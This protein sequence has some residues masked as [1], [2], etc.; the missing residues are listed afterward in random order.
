[1]K[2][3]Q[4]HAVPHLLTQSLLLLSLSL[5]FFFCSLSCC[6]PCR[7]VIWQMLKTQVPNF[8]CFFPSSTC[9]CFGQ[10]AMCDHA[11]TWCIY[12]LFV[13]L[14]RQYAAEVK[15]GCDDPAMVVQLA[16]A[17]LLVW[18]GNTLT[19]GEQHR[20]PRFLSPA[21]YCIAR[22]SV[23]EH[24]WFKPVKSPIFTTFESFLWLIYT[25]CRCL[26]S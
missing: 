1:M 16:D 17:C 9:A 8:D 6:L 7:A 14:S 3:A 18:T 12:T 19:H 25:H 10:H 11:Y 13:S 26:A 2:D 24:G 20:N 5:F 21:H 22:S 15:A 23:A 4:R